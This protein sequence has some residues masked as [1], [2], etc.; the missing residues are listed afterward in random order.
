MNKRVTTV[1][2]LILVNNIFHPPLIAEIAENMAEATGLVIDEVIG[3]IFS[4]PVTS[5]L[6]HCV[7][8]DFKMS[9]GIAVKFRELFGQVEEMQRK[10]P[11][12]G[13]IVVLKD[14]D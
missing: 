7:S 13:E 11:S 3:D 8:S 12:V 14:G 10:R 9:R 6:S 2:W 4:C 1:Y 5:S